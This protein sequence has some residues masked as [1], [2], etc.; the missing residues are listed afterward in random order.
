MTWLYV[1]GIV[2]AVIVVFDCL[3]VLTIGLLN[4]AS[5]DEPDPEVEAHVLDL[6][7]ARRR[8]SPAAGG[9]AGAP[10]EG[11]RTS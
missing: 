8:R 3:L 7:E 4:V 2:L 6:D 11:R 10:H 1:A 9:D 5:A